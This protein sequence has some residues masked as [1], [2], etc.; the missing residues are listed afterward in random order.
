[1]FDNIKSGKNVAKTQESGPQSFNQ[2]AQG[3]S[4]KGDV[5]SAGDIRIDG[6]IEGSITTKGKLVVGSTGKIEGE[7]HCAHAD[8]SGEIRGNITVTELLQLKN[9]AKLVGDIVTNKLA[10]EPGANFSGTCN[11]GAVV[12]DLNNGQQEQKRLQPKQEGQTA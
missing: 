8:V 11:M 2:V 9:T 12:K 10:I 5:T 4:V 6:T 1:M 7:V 3:T